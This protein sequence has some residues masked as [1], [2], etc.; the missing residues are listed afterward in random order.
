MLKKDLLLKI[1]EI[2][3]DLLDDENIE[4]TYDTT[5]NDIEDWDSIIHIQLI[6]SIEKYFKV[7]FST[8]EVENLKTINSIIEL[9][10]LKK[11]SSV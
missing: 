11:Q 3:K 4:V 1:S 7:R 8:I 10:E 5:A 9:I 2:L 6:V